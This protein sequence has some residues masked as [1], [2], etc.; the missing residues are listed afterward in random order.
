[1]TLSDAFFARVVSYHAVIITTGAG[2]P[3][4]ENL[5]EWSGT[6]AAVFLTVY[7]SQ[8]FDVLTTD[9]YTALGNQLLNC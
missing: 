1:M 4:P 7:P 9:D 6:D 5:I 2:G 8:G 3:A